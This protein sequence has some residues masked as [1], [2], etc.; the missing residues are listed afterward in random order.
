MQSTSNPTRRI[1][2]VQNGHLT[3]HK[4]FKVEQALAIKKVMRSTSFTIK[5]IISKQI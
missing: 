4:K 1:S 5:S 3:T 2:I